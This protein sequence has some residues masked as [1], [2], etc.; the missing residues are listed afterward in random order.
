VHPILFHLGHVAVSTQ[1]VLVAF[2]LLAALQLACLLAPR[3][4]LDPGRLWNL[5]LAALLTLFLGERM[6]VIACNLRDFIAHPF[7]M[8]GLAVVRDE[9]YFYAG[10]LLALGAG[11]AYV[12]AWRLPW[13][14]TLDCLAPAAGL[15]LA[16]LSFGSL[17]AGADFGRPTTPAWGLVYTSRLAARASNTPLG[18]P[19][20][21]VALYAGL[22]HLCLAACALWLVW[23]C[24]QPASQPGPP[25]AL[26]L[27]AAGLSTVLLEQL[28]YRLP[29][30]LLVANAFTPA[31]TLGV[32]AV[33][34]SAAMLLTDVAA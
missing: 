17:A 10:V 32:L 5:C 12:A 23:R 8:L 2:G 34:S 6:L 27:F 4:D 33:L 28:R 25:A 11:C 31:Q 13:R 29:G 7:W 24:P 16:C 1:G 19:L 9:R 26:W 18:I 22:L 20:I 14:A 3:R 15:A 30:E 21:P